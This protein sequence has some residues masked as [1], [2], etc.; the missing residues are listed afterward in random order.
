MAGWPPGQEGSPLPP[1]PACPPALGPHATYSGFA[2]ASCLWRPPPPHIR[3]GSAGRGDQQPS[4]GITQG[5]P[6]AQTWVPNAVRWLESR[7]AGTAPAFRHADRDC[8]PGSQ[9]P[10]KHLLWRLETEFEN[11][12]ISG[13]WGGG[14]S[15]SRG[16]TARACRPLE[17]WRSWPRVSLSP[18]QLLPLWP[19]PPSGYLETLGLGANSC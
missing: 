10:L 2:K 16:G 4:S 5:K 7:R 8:S 13:G 12:P 15:Q 19:P 3:A 1:I 17:P 11:P 18:A 6:S 9:S 14:P